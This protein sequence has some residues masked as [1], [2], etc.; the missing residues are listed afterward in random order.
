MTL[1]WEFTSEE[2]KLGPF[3]S[4]DTLWLKHELCLLQSCFF[5]NFSWRGKV[6]FKWHVLKSLQS[7]KFILV[8]LENK[9][10]VWIFDM[11]FFLILYDVSY[12]RERDV[13]NANT[14]IF[15][16][17]YGDIPIYQCCHLMWYCWKY[18]SNVLF[19]KIVI[20]L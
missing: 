2:A 1:M 5:C 16:C 13:W 4:N 17:L 7:S 18:L 19:P 10:F 12:L 15:L 3:V 9:H 8:Q 6:V 11:L 14:S 20:R